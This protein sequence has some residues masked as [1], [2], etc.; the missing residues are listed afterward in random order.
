MTSFQ[1]T[2]ARR[3]W[4]RRHAEKAVWG[5]AGAVTTLDMI[6]LTPGPTD[7]F[8]LF[9]LLWLMKKVANDD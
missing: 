8:A 5:L 6:Q 4:W 9:G 1:G 3:P 2:T 7:E